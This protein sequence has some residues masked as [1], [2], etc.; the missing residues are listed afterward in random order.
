[1]VCGKGGDPKRRSSL[2]ET[3]NHNMQGLR[4]RGGLDTTW[5]L[6]VTVDMVLMKMGWEDSALPVTLVAMLG[7][8]T[9]P[10]KYKPEEWLDLLPLKPPK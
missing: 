8:H 3:V 6:S 9:P 10:T 5:S 7:G 1:M 4:S 2:G